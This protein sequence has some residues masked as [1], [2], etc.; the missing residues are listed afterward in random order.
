MR[1]SAKAKQKFNPSSRPRLSANRSWSIVYDD[2]FLDEAQDPDLPMWHRLYCYARDRSNGIGHAQFGPK[3][4]S[5]LLGTSKENLAKVIR[6]AKA[7]GRITDESSAHCI[8]LP[9]HVQ[10][11]GNGAQ[12]CI[13]CGIGGGVVE[14]L[15]SQ[16]NQVVPGGQPTLAL[17]R[18]DVA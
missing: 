7:K 8:V 12:S 10:Y 1:A 15:S 2:V 18:H 17:I 5:E 14:R 3:E 16:D 9:G 13:T 6:K 11:K 4:L